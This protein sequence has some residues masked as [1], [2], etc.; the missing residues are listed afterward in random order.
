MMT[1]AMAIDK[2]QFHD[3]FIAQSSFNRQ[4]IELSVLLMNHRP[5]IMRNV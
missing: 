3:H 1:M 5:L 4:N 2:I